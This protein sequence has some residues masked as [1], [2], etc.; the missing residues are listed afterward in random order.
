MTYKDQLADPRWQKKRLQIFE[1]DKFTCQIC[2]DTETQLQV[3]H[4]EYDKKYKTLAWDYPD[5]N[6]TTLC[7]DCH[8]ELTSHI[9]FYGDDKDFSVLKVKSSDG[10]KLYYVYSKGHLHFRTPNSVCLI[11]E[12]VTH[13]IVQFLINNWLKNG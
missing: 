3:H 12:D 9:K 5:T 11:H 2:L 8:T 4:K 7:S 6:Y 1:R 10:E 13:K